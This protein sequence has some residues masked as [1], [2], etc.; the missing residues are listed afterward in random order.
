MS[1]ISPETPLRF[2]ILGSKVTPINSPQYSQGPLYS[3]SPTTYPSPATREMHDEQPHFVYNILSSKVEPIPV[4]YPSQTNGTGPSYY[5]SPQ[6][7][8]P[9]QASRGYEENLKSTHKPHYDD[10]KEQHEVPA[11]IKVAPLFFRILGLLVGLCLFG[12]QVTSM[13]FG[14]IVIITLRSSS[15]QDTLSVPKDFYPSTGLNNLAIESWFLLTFYVMEMVASLIGVF[16]YV[17][18]IFTTKLLHPS[19]EMSIVHQAEVEAKEKTIYEVTC[20]AFGCTTLLR[21]LLY[22]CILQKLAYYHLY[23]WQ[24]LFKLCLNAIYSAY[25]TIAGIQTTVP[26]CISIDLVSQIK[27]ATILCLFTILLTIFIYVP[28]SH[29]TNGIYKFLNIPSG[30]WAAGVFLT[31]TA[32]QF[33]VFEFEFYTSSQYG[34]FEMSSLQITALVSYIFA[35]LGTVAAMNGMGRTV[36]LFS[37]NTYNSQRARAQ[38]HTDAKMGS[39]LSPRGLFGSL[40]AAIGFRALFAFVLPSAMLGLNVC[41]RAAWNTWP[42]FVMNYAFC[43]AFI[44]LGGLSICGCCCSVREAKKKAKPGT[45]SIGGVEGADNIGMATLFAPLSSSNNKKEGGGDA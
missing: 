34:G 16:N 25:Y 10:G 8:A 42:W 20:G 33:M 5:E 22:D 27:T 19:R 38:D 21:I 9:L 32:A 13:A 24:D 12:L 44:V 2:N 7:V 26:Y 29:T 39:M 4:A 31:P 3:S 1:S 43:I 35:A 11:T 6:H 17:L 45:R 30:I 14:L 23:C 40:P 15:F 18:L 36:G 28:M 37:G 41:I